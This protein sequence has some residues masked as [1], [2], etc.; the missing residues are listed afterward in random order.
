MPILF[1]YLLRE[2]GKVFTMCFTGL[3]TIYLVIDFFEKVRRFLRYDA[4]W[5]DVL[6]YFLLKT[7]AISFQIAPLAILMATLLTFGLLSRGNEITAMRSC[8]ISLPW[9]TT[10]FIVFA[11]GIALIL[12]LF[13]STVIPLAASKSE[14][15]RTTRIE[16]KSPATAV[17]LQQPWTRVGADSLMHVTSVSVDGEL[18]GGVR[19]F[20]FDHNFQLINMT[21]ADE[22]RYVDRNWTLYQGRH[23]RF[24]PDG[25]VSVTEFD[26]EAI[27][28]TLIPDDFTTWLSGDS[29][30]MTFHDIRAYTRRRHQQDSQASR[31]KTD[32]YSRIAFP[33]VTV[34]MVMVGIALSLRRSGTRGSS[35][36]MGIGQ[37]LAVGFCYW[38]THS[39]AI[40]LGRGGVLTP[41]IA[42]WMANVLFMS[43]GLYLMFKVRY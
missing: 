40:A 5:L 29:E 32:Y 22:A 35:M 19:L 12:L 31:L 9:I 18:L 23:R 17:K 26:R 28:L 10:P 4:S 25:T 21:E 34:I 11:A 15:I 16:K 42:G 14:E 37:A 41:L 27:A 33:F 1:R 6:T 38:T 3:M 7:P 43:F 24:S 13:S 20:Q 2:Y 30:L 36:A 8:G 39:I